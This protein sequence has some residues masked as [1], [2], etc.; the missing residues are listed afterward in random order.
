LTTTYAGQTGIDRTVGRVFRKVE[1]AML[2]FKSWVER[3]VGHS[4]RQADTL[5]VKQV[6]TRLREGA[7]QGADA[8]APLPPSQHEAGD[9]ANPQWGRQTPSQP[10][11]RVA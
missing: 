8:M 2:S 1:H 6:F 7:Y 3:V 10:R 4:Q 5:T 11:M 9:D